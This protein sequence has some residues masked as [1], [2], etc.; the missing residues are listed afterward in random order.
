MSD[1]WD[2]TLWQVHLLES[3]LHENVITTGLA[4]SAVA[5]EQGQVA[6]PLHRIA[7]IS[8]CSVSAA[9]NRLATLLATSYIRREG[10]HQ[11][12][13]PSGGGP[14]RR[15]Q[16]H[17][18]VTI[19][20][21]VPVKPAFDKPLWLAQLHEAGLGP[22]VIAIGVA[23]AMEADRD[24]FA[25]PGVR[26]LGQIAGCSSDTAHRRLMR[27]EIKRLARRNGTQEGTWAKPFTRWQL[28]IT[29][30]VGQAHRGSYS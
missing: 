19:V 23:L 12:A 4:F 11:R 2:K 1:G 24:G 7:R 29:P 15:Y 5:D 16:L 21:P 26:R 28:V 9:Y 20:E 6:A 10:W 17:T 25:A 22:G 13:A 8:A 27:L 14:V 30:D 18:P 3:G